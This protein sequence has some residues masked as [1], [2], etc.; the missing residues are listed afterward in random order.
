VIRTIARLSA[1]AA[2]VVL[3][4]T[5]AILLRVPGLTGPSTSGADSDP[6][7]GASAVAPAS[8]PPVAIPTVPPL[9][10]SAPATSGVASPRPTTAIVHVAENGADD[11][12]DGSVERPWRTLGHALTTAPDGA[13]IQLGPGTFDAATITRPGQAIAGTPGQTS[14]VG[15]LTI[16]A[17]DVTVSG[18]T[19]TGVQDTYS[20]GLIVNRARRATIVGNEVSGNP[21]GIEL[22]DAL[23]ARI[24]QNLV[25]DNGYGLEVHG[26]TDGTVIRHNQIVENDRRVDKWRGA[27]GINLYLV[28]GGL[29]IEDNE[30]RGND[31]VGIE[32]YGASNVDI[33]GNELSGSNDLIETGTENDKP[34]DDMTITRNAFYNDGVGDGHE[35]RGIYLRCATHTEV[36]WNTFD[37][38]DRFA[39][40]LYRGSGGFNGPVGQVRISHNIIAGGRAFSIDSAMSDDITVDRDVIWPC[41]ADPCP[42]LGRQVAFVHDHDGT[43]RLTSF[44]A[45]TGFEEHAIFA[46][47]DFVDADAH[48]YRLRDGSPLKGRAGLEDAPPD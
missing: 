25:T 35:V 1:V 13:T 27:G 36:S 34:C 39:I 8:Q 15:G 46:D 12:G 19:L 48:D 3:V 38:L 32:V 24:E 5:A 33:R 22:Q 7:A 44:R 17:D 21:F 6:S 30:I 37:R 18:L 45:W 2:V 20:G 14:V 42:V 4:V 47:P 41:Q 29:T 31:D 10:T 26:R 23:D 11:L 16:A 43:A 9:S 40:G 28:K